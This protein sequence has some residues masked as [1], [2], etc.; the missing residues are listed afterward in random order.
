MYGLDGVILCTDPEDI[1]NNI[2]SDREAFLLHSQRNL[3]KTIYIF[4][5]MCV[6][7]PLCLSVSPSICL[8]VCSNSR[9]PQRTSASRLIV[10]QHIRILLKVEQSLRAFDTENY[11]IAC[12][13]LERKSINVY[14][15]EKCLERNCTGNLET[16]I[17]SVSLA[18]CDSDKNEWRGRFVHFQLVLNWE[19][20]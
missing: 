6:S 19:P 7:L 11:V 1:T 12:M 15:S 10:S 14:G 3:A 13:H 2:H 5:S 20:G 9:T 17:E 16:Q 8:L 18:L 4:V